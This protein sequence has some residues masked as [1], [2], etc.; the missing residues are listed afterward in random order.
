MAIGVGR[1]MGFRLPENFRSP[2]LALNIQDFWRRWHITLSLWLR[3]YLYIPLGGSRRGNRYLNLIITMALG[4]AV[5]RLEYPFSGLGSHA[6]GGA[7]RR[8]CLP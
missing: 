8:P 1:L 3:D 2:Y 6:W 4:G 7:G 5:A